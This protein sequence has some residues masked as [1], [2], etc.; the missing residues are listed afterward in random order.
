M[1]DNPFRM[2][3]R[4]IPIS[5]SGRRRCRT[6]FPEYR[7]NP[8]GCMLAIRKKFHAGKSDR[9]DKR[10]T[11]YSNRRPWALFFRR[12]V[13]SYPGTG[14]MKMG[15]KKKFSGGN[16]RISRNGRGKPA[17]RPIAGIT[18]AQAGSVPPIA[19]EA[20]R[21]AP[22][23]DFAGQTALMKYLCKKIGRHSDNC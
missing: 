11:G 9:R 8:A 15:A 10:D 21:S 23:A 3:D 6:I 2:M 12:A 16:G 18:A 14:R 20:W 7:T 13:C 4:P 5:D 17:V 1:S 22:A 19:D